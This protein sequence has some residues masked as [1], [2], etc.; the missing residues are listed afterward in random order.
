MKI[1]PENIREKKRKSNKG[2][3]KREGKK[4]KKG[5]QLQT[6]NA[7][8]SRD[9]YSNR[10]T[11]KQP[12]TAY[13][14]QNIYP[15]LCSTP[16][17]WHLG[18]KMSN[19]I[20]FISYVNISTASCGFCI[21]FLWLTHQRFSQTLVFVWQNEVYSIRNKYVTVNRTQIK[22]YPVRILG[23]GLNTFKPLCVGYFR[24]HSSR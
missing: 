3:R 19:S 12:E 13:D 6:R 2:L 10:Q 20:L 1:Q 15:S 11:S 21:S 7:L 5:R 8:V 18:Y 17:V 4:W 23:C 22:R 9:S 14:S 24:L 16:P